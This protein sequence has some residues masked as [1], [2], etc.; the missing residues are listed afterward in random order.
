MSVGSD[1]GSVRVIKRAAFEQAGTGSRREF[2]QDSF[3]RIGNQTRGRYVTGMRLLRLRD[4]LTEREWEIISTLERVRVATTAQLE[5]LHFAE[6]SRRMA[7]KQL[8]SLVNRRVLYRLPRAIGGSRAGST[9]HVYALGI[10]GQR[11]V[12]LVEGQQIARPWAIGGAFLAHSLA[13]TDVYVGLALAERA[14]YLG[15]VRFVSEPG[16]WRTFFG[17][18][19]GRAV[20]KPD[21][22]VVA[23][24]R[25]YE[26]HWFIEVDRGTEHPP[27]LTRKCGVYVSYRR[28]GREQAKHGVFPRVLWLVPDERRADVVRGA[29]RRQPGGAAEMFV[30]ALSCRVVERVLQGAAP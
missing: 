2:G 1:R 18:G 12:G 14:G 17:P 13:V 24:V 21:A 10:A 8:A 3:S 27:T 19:G 4:R 5:A 9:G 23:F 16:S 26:D 30:V 15:N 7:R 25:G 11:L 22:Y 20:V 29:I 28:S 6:V